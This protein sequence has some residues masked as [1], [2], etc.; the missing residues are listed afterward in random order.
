MF[1]KIAFDAL[2][3]SFLADRIDD[4]IKENRSFSIGNAIE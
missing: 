3:E 1:L 4:L 2:E